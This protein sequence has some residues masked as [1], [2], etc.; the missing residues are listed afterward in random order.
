MFHLASSSRFDLKRISICHQKCFPTSFS[1]R[2]GSAYTCKTL[3]WF[4]VSEN[5]F[6]F[7][8]EAE[9]NIA[10]YCG[11]FRSSYPGEGSTSGMLQ[12]AMKEAIKGVTRKPYLFFHPELTRRYPLI[13]K[14]I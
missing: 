7:H 8:V 10:G 9:N 11:G 1:S 6:L 3:E 5:R 14:N 2:L 12:Y 13:F 4:L